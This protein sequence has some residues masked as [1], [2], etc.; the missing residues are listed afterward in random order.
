MCNLTDSLP[1]N[2]FGLTQNQKDI[3]IEKR[4]V[5]RYNEILELRPLKD[6]ESKDLEKATKRIELWQ[7]EE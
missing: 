4:R 1:Q 7:S 6:W 2:W 3:L 5:D